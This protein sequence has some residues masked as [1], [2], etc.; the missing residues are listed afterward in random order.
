MLGVEQKL[1][2]SEQAPLNVAGVNVLR[3]LPGS[4]RVTV[5]GARTTVDPFVTDWLYLNVRRLLLFLEESIQDGIRWAVFEPNDLGLWK[6]LHRVITAFLR[7]Q[8]RAG[9]LFGATEEEAFRVRIDEALNPPSTRNKGYLYIEIKVA[10]VRP[11][12]F[13]VVRI[14][15]STAAPT[16]RR[17]DD[18]TAHRPDQQLQLPVEIDGIQVGGFSEASGLESTIEAI[19][20]REGGDN[21]TVRKLPGK[22]TTPT[23]S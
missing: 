2:D 3:I 9:A 16:W 22:T 19:E 12:E 14:G 21:T 10:P 11:A 20:Y 6:S 15:C 13:V 5:W 17:G 7:E 18:G 8:W 23:S 4:N 1:T